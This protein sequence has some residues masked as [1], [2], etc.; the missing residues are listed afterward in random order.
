M[1]RAKLFSLSQY[2]LP[3][4]LIS[5]VI[6][7]VAACDNS[8]VKNTFIE[9][10]IKAYDVN[11]GEALEEDPR[12]YA[13]FNDFFTRALKPEARPIGQGLVS[14]ADGVLSQF[15]AI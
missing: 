11:M 6:G 9:R 13:C 10:F 12:A 7:R 5:R 14:P 3:Q 15:G 4:H 2:T 1:D 8:W